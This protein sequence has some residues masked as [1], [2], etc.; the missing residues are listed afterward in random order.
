MSSGSA[1]ASNTARG[2]LLPLLAA[3]AAEDCGTGQGI[4]CTHRDR[5][6]V[7]PQPTCPRC[8]EQDTPLL[9]TPL[10]AVPA[11][12]SCSPACCSQHCWCRV[13]A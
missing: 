9:L 2:V 1:G 10:C 6:Q 4:T 12:P 13:H 3:D 11:P 7:R 8:A 5:Q